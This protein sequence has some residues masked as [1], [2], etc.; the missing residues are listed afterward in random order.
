[1]KF[2]CVRSTQ[3]L[4]VAGIAVLAA[5]G[6]GA[7][8]VASK[9]LGVV[10]EE[11]LTLAATTILARNEVNCGESRSPQIRCP[12][13]G[14]FVKTP[15]SSRETAFTLKRTE[16]KAKIAGNISRTEVV[17]KFENPFNEPLEAVYVFPLPDEA[18]V[19]DMEIKIGDRTIK[20]DIKRRDEA[21][22]IYERARQQGRTA[23]L[24][25]QERDNIFTQSLAN[26]KPGEKIEVTIRYTET[27]KFTDGD[28]EFV[29]PMVVGPRYISGNSTPPDRGGQG[30][31]APTRAGGGSD[32]D[33]INPPVLPPG[34]RSGH[35]IGITVE[36]DAGIPISDVRSASHQITTSRSGNTVSVQLANTDTI[37]NKD[38]ILR[39][40][41]AGETTRST[42]L[43]QADKRGGHFAVYLIPALNYPPDR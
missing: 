20:A 10:P 37:P 26:I 11:F 1:M 18:A 19:D 14:L 36:I 13:G 29:F 31:T 24:L 38:L 3:Q 35:D 4:F 27:L 6:A 30:G 8:L 17:Q 42:V 25:E 12:V 40:R 43:T 5:M 9:A 2:V 16:V 15:N 28:Y 23:G 21:L 32:A 7:G 22:E 41:V 33:R 34:V 39:Y